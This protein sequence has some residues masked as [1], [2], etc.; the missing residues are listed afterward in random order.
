M[1][2]D[3]S[4]PDQPQKRGFKLTK[5]IKLSILGTAILAVSVFLAFFIPLSMSDGTEKYD[6][7]K[8]KSAE[9]VLM[10]APQLSDGI[11]KVIGGVLKIRVEDVYETPPETAK[12]WCGNSYK[13]GD[14]YYSVVVGYRT[15]F[16]ILSESFPRHD[17]CLSY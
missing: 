3:E 16:G 8:K 10:W 2:N 17:A 13:E 7:V 14:K 5:K 11:E 12:S 1:H 15:F 4:S 9:A 6:G